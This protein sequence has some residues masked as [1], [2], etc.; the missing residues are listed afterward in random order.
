MQGSCKLQR[1][2]PAERRQCSP[3]LFTWFYFMLGI[4]GPLWAPR[5]YAKRTIASSFLFSR[6]IL[7]LILWCDIIDASTCVFFQKRLL[8][9]ELSPSRFA[10]CL[11]ALHLSASSFAFPHWFRRLGW[12]LQMERWRP[13]TDEWWA[14]SS[15]GLKGPSLS[16]KRTLQRADEIPTISLYANPSLIRLCSTLGCTSL[17][18]HLSVSRTDESIQFSQAHL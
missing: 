14:Y 13:D 16:W 5:C 11:P 10:K 15:C 12:Q 7:L 6:S 1:K 2:A 3:P 18:N 17:C 8:Y 4:Q 9:S